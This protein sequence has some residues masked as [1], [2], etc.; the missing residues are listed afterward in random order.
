MLDKL[1]KNVFSIRKFYKLCLKSAQNIAILLLGTWS[2]T[3]L[4]FLSVWYSVGNMYTLLVII[5]GSV[6]QWTL[7]RLTILYILKNNLDLKRD[8]NTDLKYKLAYY[9]CWNI[10]MESNL[11]IQIMYLKILNIIA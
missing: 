9:N 10:S 8:P 1:E 5:H 3:S 7:L 2:K 4:S 11:L 6:D